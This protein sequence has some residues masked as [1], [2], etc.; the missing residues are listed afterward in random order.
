MDPHAPQT[1]PNWRRRLA[2]FNLQTS[3]EKAAEQQ[4]T[5]GRVAGVWLG[6]LYTR[7]LETWRQRFHQPPLLKNNE[8]AAVRQKT[9]AE[10]GVSGLFPLIYPR[11][12]PR[13]NLTAKIY[14]TSAVNKQRTRRG[15]AKNGG[16]VYASRAGTAYLPQHFEN[17]A[18]V[19]STQAHNE[20]AAA[21]Q[22]TAEGLTVRG[23][24]RL[25]YPRALKT[26]RQRFHQPPPLKNN[27]RDAEQRR[28]EEGFTPQGLEQLIYPRALKTW[29]Q[30]FHQ[31]PLLKNN[32][33]DAEQRRT[34]EGFTPQGLEQL[35]YPRALKTWRRLAQ[36][37]LHTSSKK[38][39][40]QAAVRQRKLQG[41]GASGLGRLISR[42]THRGWG[43]G[44]RFPACQQDGFS[45]RPKRSIIKLLSRLILGLV[46]LLWL[47][48]WALAAE[49]QR[50][51]SLLKLELRL[52]PPALTER[53]NLEPSNLAEQ[54]PK[55]FYAQQP[56]T[57]RPPI[58]KALSKARQPQNPELP[59]TD[60]A[61]KPD[62]KPTEAQA[63]IQRLIFT[64]QLAKLYSRS[65]RW[66]WAEQE[67]MAL[68]DQTNDP[69]KL[70]LMPVV[71]WQEYFYLLAQASF[72]AGD[73]ALSISVSSMLLNDFSLPPERQQELRFMRVVGYFDLYQPYAYPLRKQAIEQGWNLRKET[74]GLRRYDLE[75]AYQAWE[76]RSVPQKSPTLAGVLGVVPG[77][78]SWYA[79]RPKQAIYSFVVVSLFS[80]AYLEAN[81][82]DQPLLAAPFLFLSVSFYA[83]SIYAGVSSTH[84]YNSTQHLKSLNRIRDNYNLY[85]LP[86]F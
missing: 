55:I 49:T 4:S 81:R 68:F 35:I 69:P 18:A 45:T 22:K 84:D 25:I 31:P 70:S 64:L 63:E 7:T 52:P 33:R 40:E 67:L 41:E 47:Q 9:R 77:L 82:S 15:A 62:I 51:T 74:S 76:S 27:E 32:E 43:A 3:S 21:Q 72:F 30:R 20:Q 61:N 50:T 8:Q 56:T 83:G 36:F 42:S 57:D 28:T 54:A 65:S 23:L 24:G 1:L 34:E 60:A 79:D 48:P 38:A 66:S 59:E 46:G 86:S 19:G 75:Q 17:L 14:L 58:K 12:L 37:N 13:G 53:F 16:G 39:A 71:F 2:Q 80:L 6:W 73:Y 44:H 10:L 11:S 85:H 78:G 5:Q 29:R 26:W